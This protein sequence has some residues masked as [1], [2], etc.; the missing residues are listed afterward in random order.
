MMAALFPTFQHW[1][2]IDS[3]T[4]A[5]LFLFK[6]NI[7][8][9]HPVCFEIFL[10]KN[11]WEIP[12]LIF[13]QVLV[14]FWKENNSISCA[15]SEQNTEEFQRRWKI[16]RNSYQRHMF[17]TKTLR[18][19]PK[20]SWL[21]QGRMVFPF[22]YSLTQNDVTRKAR[23][24]LTRLDLEWAWNSN[25]VQQLFKSESFP[26]DSCIEPQSVPSSHEFK[27]QINFSNPNCALDAQ[28]AILRV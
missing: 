23:R 11:S 12:K 28:T 8:V 10:H 22:S 20:Y 26:R 16:W 21:S 19:F 14:V 13:K 24:L 27:W 4:L 1:M 17:H 25:P 6:C 5:Y 3:L 15:F 7:R 2:L 9:E 18:N